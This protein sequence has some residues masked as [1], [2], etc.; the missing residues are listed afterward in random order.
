MLDATGLDEE[1][2][3]MFDNPLEP[4]RDTE[5]ASMDDTEEELRMVDSDPDIEVV[6]GVVN[7]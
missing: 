6:C 4:V 1:C 7:V 3:G 5:E 2:D